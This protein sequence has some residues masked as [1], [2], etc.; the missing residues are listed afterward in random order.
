MRGLVVYE[1]MFGN[2]RRVAEAIAQSLGQFGEVRAVRA[3]EVAREDLHNLDLLVVGAPTHTWGMPR[4]NTRHGALDN[5]RKSG[6]DLVLQPNADSLPGVR[7]WLET[8]GYVHSLGAVFDTRFKAPL[9][10]TGRAANG[11]V[12]VLQHHDVEI[13]TP[14]QSFLVDRKNHLIAGEL[15][16]AITWGRQLGELVVAQTMVHR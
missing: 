15:E 13:V 4:P 14:P 3:H 1:S 5:V 9:A 8:L 10:F 12:K 2:T 16:K 6:G 7:E 11:I